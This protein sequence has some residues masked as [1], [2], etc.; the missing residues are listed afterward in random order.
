MRKQRNGVHVLVKRTVNLHADRC[1]DLSMV[2]RLSR[3]RV[4]LT[5]SYVFAVKIRV[6]E[7]RYFEII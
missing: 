5:F 1:S 6:R 4:S 2:Y 7:Y 3:P